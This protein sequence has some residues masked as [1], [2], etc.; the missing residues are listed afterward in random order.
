MQKILRD[1]PFPK[2]QILGSLKLKEFADNNFKCDK[3]GEKFYKSVE[4]TVEKGE[5]AHYKNFLLFPQCFQKICNTDMYKA[6][7]IWERVKRVKILFVLGSLGRLTFCKC[8]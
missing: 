8:L 2:Q 3:I 7:L 4:N 6:G 1:Q 5:I